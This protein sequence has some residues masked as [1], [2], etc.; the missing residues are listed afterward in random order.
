MNE[1]KLRSMTGIVFGILTVGSILLHPFAF[2]LVFQL[3][4]LI[5]LHEFYRLCRVAGHA[6]QEIYGLVAGGALFFAVSFLPFYT[7]P[8][9]SYFL[10][11]AILILPFI[12]EL[13]RNRPTPFQNI[14]LT[15]LG[16][17]YIAL[18]F[19]LLSWFYS[20]SPTD[21]N[22]GFMI[23]FFLLIW[24]N[25]MGAYFFGIKFG[26]NKLFERISPKKTIEG[27][28]GGAFLTILLAVILQWLI[29]FPAF[30]TWF[31]VAAIC[32]LAGLAGDLTASMFKRSIDVKDSGNLFPGHG[33]I[34]DRFDSLFIAAPFVFVF[35]IL[36]S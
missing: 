34:I 11:I 5:G 24:T 14:A 29:P 8:L 10:A 4:L 21:Y 15:Y 22:W 23:G 20:F 18:P 32:V 2:A 30:Y 33:G 27:S 16:L 35:I 19:S 9:K 12:F 25:D 17:I 28:L 3:F 26:K 36:I 1:L 31:A 13:Y 6:P 7:P